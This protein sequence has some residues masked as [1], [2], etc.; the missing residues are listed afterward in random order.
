[1]VACCQFVTW[2]LHT[3][4]TALAACTDM[5]FSANSSCLCCSGT[6]HKHQQARMALTL[7]LLSSVSS[8]IFRLQVAN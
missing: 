3:K 6:A 4:V 1:M 2:H 8:P 7:L 5:L